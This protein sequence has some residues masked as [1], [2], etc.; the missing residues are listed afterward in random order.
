MYD[1]KGRRHR[2]IYGAAAACAATVDGR[3]ALTSIALL[4]DG[5]CHDSVGSTSAVE[6]SKTKLSRQWLD[7][8]R[9]HRRRSGRGQEFCPKLIDLTASPMPPAVARAPPL[10]PPPRRDNA[11]RGLPERHRLLADRRCALLGAAAPQALAGAGRIGRASASSTAARHREPGGFVE[12]NFELGGGSASR[13]T[14]TTR[15]SG[16]MRPP[17]ASAGAAGWRVGAQLEIARDQEPPPGR[18]ARSRTSRS[19]CRTSRA[20]RPCA[21]TRPRA[22]GTCSSWAA[23]CPT[24]GRVVRGGLHERHDRRHAPAAP[25][26][27]APA[28]AAAACSQFNISAWHAPSLRGPWTAR[29]RTT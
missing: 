24:I 21:G 5:G 12:A 14:P 23:A 4:A 20:A 7:K 22:C 1:G 18:A 19:S 26:P 11:R 15:G 29:A 27:A 3:A 9:S 28:A 16:H 6:R 25:A 8:F 10:A 13:A 17:R 2:G